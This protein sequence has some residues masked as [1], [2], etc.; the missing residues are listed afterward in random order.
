[1]QHPVR[2][3]LISCTLVVAAGC[4]GGTIMVAPAGSHPGTGATPK[5]S[6]TPSATPTP[7][8]A[9]TPS[10]SPSPTGSAGAVAAQINA[11]MQG[12]ET[13]YQGLPHQNLQADLQS[14]ATFA[15]TQAGFTSAQSQS[16]GV[17]AT[18]A[19][20]ALAYFFA[21]KGLYTTAQGPPTPPTLI[22]GGSPHEIAFLEY[23]YRDIGFHPSRQIAF[24]A[25]FAPT[26]YPTATYRAEEGSASLD[27]VAALRNGGVDVLDISTHGGVYKK[28][29]GAQY[30]L[31]STTP[32]TAANMQKWSADLQAGN[33]VY[34]L[35]L[36]NPS[37]YVALA[38]FA[39]TPAFITS[40]VTFNPGAIVDNISC[41]GAN[42]LIA[43][44]V[45]N[46][47]FAA[48]VGMYYGWTKSVLGGDSDD[49]DAFLL[50][51]TLGEQNPSASG[52]ATY[53]NQRSPAQRPFSLFET[54]NQMSQETR[55]DPL[56]GSTDNYVTSTALDQQ[57]AAM[58]MIFP[59]FA[60]GPVSHFIEMPSPSLAAGAP[61]PANNIIEYG[62]PSIA[63]A[64]VNEAPTA[65]LTLYGEFPSAQGS[66]VMS[67]SES[68]PAGATPLSI[69]SWSP[70]TITAT[71][72]PEGPAAAGYLYVISAGGVPSNPVP[73]T[74]W[75]GTAQAVRTFTLGSAPF[76]NT[77]SG[78]ATIAANFSFHFRADVHP[79]VG[80]IDTDAQPQNFFFPNVESDATGTFSTVTG[81]WHNTSQSQSATISIDSPPLMVPFPS[82]SQGSFNITPNA[83]DISQLQ[84]D[85]CNDGVS[86]LQSGPSNGPFN[87]FCAG[88]SF[89]DSNVLQCTDNV[90]GN[91]CGGNPSVNGF[92]ISATVYAINATPFVLDSA[93]NVSVMPNLPASDGPQ[94]LAQFSSTS[95]TTETFAISAPVAPPDDMTPAARRRG[96]KRGFLVN[97]APDP[98]RP[99]SPM[100]GR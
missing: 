10:P 81:Q 33:L 35:T 75:A 41:F 19:N 67:S 44:S 29:S 52:L 42:P 5:P 73:L 77:G 71:I 59:P 38:T 96:D 61:I 84:Q 93:Y 37:E 95:S 7:G 92:G 57:L 55:N 21:D 14:T 64:E 9:A 76:N 94:Q 27:N 20:G 100:L 15:G 32:V 12:V 48:N 91:D 26:G 43:T 51:R 4:S 6:A 50:D 34:G 39:F 80:I 79:V 8:G 98:S 89:G 88:L 69:T 85:G 74:Q 70:S 82:A 83:I 65:T 62:R 30:I 99:S 68:S 25:A 36:Y 18:L 13:Y 58:N 87:V 22:Q 17:T 16:D 97:A 28:P 54:Y 24:A 23:D 72:P 31:L 90:M 40:H 66:L 86:G 63:Q 56:V 78:T 60:D 49:S 2:A 46:T 47:L 53:V 11:A 3:I 1:M 45:Q